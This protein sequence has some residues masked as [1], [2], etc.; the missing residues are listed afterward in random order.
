MTKFAVKNPISVLVLAVILL[1]AG[2]MS[3]SSLPRESFPEI[4]IPYIFVNTVLPGASPEDIEKLVTRK[5]EDNLSGM[6]GV[7]KISSQ[8]IESVSLIT[9][10]FETNVDVETALRRVRDKVEVAKGD[11][12]TDAEDPMVQE[13]NFSSIPILVVSMT[14]DYDMERLEPLAEQLQTKLEG[15]PGVLEVKLSGKRDREIAVDADPDRLRSYHLS[16]NDLATAIGNQHRNVPGGTLITGGNRFTLKVT[17][18]LEKPEDFREIVVKEEG[19]RIIRLKDVAKVDF[20]YVRERTSIARLDG[21]PALTLSI[22]KR[23]GEN[24]IRIADEVKEIVDASSKQWPNGTHVAM[25]GDQSKEIREMV[26]EL[27]N[28]II[29]GVIL[30]VALISFFLG[31]RNSFFISTAIPFS[32]M[33]GFIVLELMGITLNMVVLFSLVI[34]LGMLV[35]DGIVVVENI[36]RHMAL[37]KSRAQAAIDGTREVMIPVTTATFTTVAA[38][39]P[40]MWIPGIMGQFMKY[41]P[42]TVSVTLIGSLFV[43]FVFNP[44]FA[45]LFM[46]THA[47]HHDEEGGGMFLRFRG[48]YV[49]VLEKLVGRPVLVALGCI[50]FVISG[51]IVYGILGTG[52]VF[53]PTTEPKNVAVQIE[54]PLGLDIEKT[55]EAVAKVEHLILNMPDSVQ[56]LTTVRG[57]VG[58][59]KS[60]D[61]GGT[62]EPHKGYV[63]ME[64]A[65]YEHRRVPSWTTMAWLGDTLESAMPGWKVTVE[66]EQNGPPVGKP[67]N[68]E[69]VGEDYTVMARLADS[70]QARLKTVPNLV[71]V[72]SDYD[73]AQPELRVDI[74]RDQ[75]LFLGVSTVAAASAVRSAIY[76]IEAGKYRKGEDEYKIMVRNSPESRA[77]KSGL[78]DVMVP[79]SNGSI[80]ITSVASIDEGASLAKVLHLD[81]KRTIQVWGELA[82]GVGDEQTVK[83]AAQ[84]AVE[85]LNVPDGY[86]VQ[87]GSDNRDQEETQAFIIKAFAIAIAL[88]FLI[89]VGQFNSIFQPILVV[90]GIFLALGGVFWGLTITQVTFSFMMTGVGV[91]ALAGVVAKNSIIL[92]EFTNKLREEGMELRAAVI[93]AGKVR[94]RPVLL[95]AVAAM[96]G[97]VPMATGK[98]FDFSHMRIVTKT[99]S[100]LMWE[101]LAWAIF[102]GLL[103]NTFLVLVA[104]PTFYYSYYRFTGWLKKK[105]GK[106]TPASET[107]VV[108][109]H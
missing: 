31:L 85:T 55:D 83:L 56:D 51:M 98:G 99:E 107:H 41:L 68:L 40:L 7:K 38:F 27:Q 66:K 76:G 50:G 34:A 106:N 29:T 105:F 108:T 70:I 77:T 62:A 4:K 11:L 24:L 102:W 8:S 59:A 43:A 54:G 23:T 3:Y 100:S 49:A 84:K 14:S 86:V 93:E 82:P 91:V 90:I 104:T 32:M 48:M 80:P 89:M 57:I 53:F 19:G 92:I 58:S 10:E 71:N 72:G 96:I 69:I 6:D 1:A 78:N 64:F 65:D 73:P 97:L 63:D 15:V 103:F 75:A 45:S 60:G 87:T 13:L 94:M 37:G 16:L 20:T 33:L 44:V 52:M 47:K 67:V 22:S 36:Y 18:E 74:D 2:W 42:I 46:N 30:V 25:M 26:V 35:D 101:P 61:F 88:V 12:P 109:Q 39:L 21:K 9:V 5:I 81:R 17:G 95:T 28:H 79:S